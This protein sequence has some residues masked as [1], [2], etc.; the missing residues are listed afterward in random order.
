MKKI[1]VVFSAL[2]LIVTLSLSS[3]ALNGGDKDKKCCKTENKTEC[4]KDKEH[5]KKEGDKKCC[6]KSDKK[7]C[8]KEEKPKLEEEK[9]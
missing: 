2:A 5:C 4:N 8:S 1:V 9:K 3:F 7:C 6:K